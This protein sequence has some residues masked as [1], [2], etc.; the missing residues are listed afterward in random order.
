M[1]CS[2][3]CAVG[4]DS[5]ISFEMDSFFLIKSVHFCFYFSVCL[6]FSVLPQLILSH[7]KS[8]DNNSS[9]GYGSFIKSF[10]TEYTYSKWNTGW[11][12]TWMTHW[13]LCKTD[14][15]FQDELYVGWTNE[16]GHYKATVLH[17]LCWKLHRNGHWCKNSSKK[18]EKHLNRVDLWALIHL[19]L[20]AFVQPNVDFAPKLCVY[21]SLMND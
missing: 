20:A 7:N 4:M 5:V 10:S 19:I 3:L 11:K 12:L 16:A 1:M 2:K 9:Y 14:F 8:I 15:L 21:L 18:M 13:K 17:L 6:Y